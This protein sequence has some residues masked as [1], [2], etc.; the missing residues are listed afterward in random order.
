VTSQKP[1]DPA[2][3]VPQTGLAEFLQLFVS[4]SLVKGGVRSAFSVGTAR[5]D[6]GEGPLVGAIDSSFPAAN[7]WPFATITVRA[8]YAFL[9]IP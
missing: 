7:G 4:F 8:R 2:P 9:G 3:A 5:S 6:D 1:K